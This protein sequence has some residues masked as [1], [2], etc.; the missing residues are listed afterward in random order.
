MAE[1]RPRSSFDVIID[2]YKR[3]IDMTLVEAN[4]RRTVE[5]RIRELQRLLAF[6]ETLRRASPPAPPS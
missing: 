2:R 4:L 5:D 3:D 1:K 6:A